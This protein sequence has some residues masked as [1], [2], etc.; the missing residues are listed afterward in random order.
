VG[1]GSLAAGSH[2]RGGWQSLFELLSIH[3]LTNGTTSLFRVSNVHSLGGNVSIGQSVENQY[4]LALQQE[5]SRIKP[6]RDYVLV[7]TEQSFG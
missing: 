5:I 6:S 7:E 2:E 3:L 1:I 4:H